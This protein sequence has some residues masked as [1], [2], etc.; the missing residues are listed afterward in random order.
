MNAE[1]EK[2]IM[3]NLN[4]VRIVINKTFKHCKDQEDLFQVGCVGLIKAINNYDDSKGVQLSTFA[5]TYIQGEIKRYLRDSCNEI[6]VPRPVKEKAVEVYRIKD[7]MAL[8]MGR[9]PT[10][11]ELSKRLDMDVKTLS[12][13]LMAKWQVNS[14]DIPVFDTDGTEV[15]FVDTLLDLD[16]DAAYNCT[17]ESLKVLTEK[18]KFVIICRLQGYSQTEIAKMLD[19]SQMSISRYENKALQK[20]KGELDV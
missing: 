5:Y 6:H 14:L 12:Y 18:E 8:E 11:K 2:L 4:L 9:E 17:Q 19:V 10:L 15:M 7:D 1:R 16:A 3:D 13:V 20:L